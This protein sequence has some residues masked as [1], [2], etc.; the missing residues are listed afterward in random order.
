M[1][2][3]ELA[4]GLLDP[5]ALGDLSLTGLTAD[6]RQ[7]APGHLFIA[8][9]FLDKPGFKFDGHDFIAAAVQAGAV[10]VLAADQAKAEAAAAGTPVVVV[11]D[12]RRLLP[13]LA[14]RWYGEPSQDLRLVGVSGTNGK[15]TTCYLLDQIFRAVGWPTVLV[16]TVETRLAGEVRPAANTTPD[17]VTLQKLW[18]EAV[19]RGVV[20]GSMEVSSHALDQHRTDGTRYEVAI[21]TNLTQDHLDYHLDLESYFLAKRKL[22]VDAE[23]RPAS[24]INADDPY[25][26]RLL[27][28]LPDAWSF[29]L[30]EPA[31]VRAE[32]VTY[33]L[34]GSAF[35]V[36]TPSGAWSQRLPI[37]GRYN[38]AN[39]LGAIG[40]ALRLGLPAETINAALSMATGAP[41][42]LE[43]VDEGQPY[44]I[45]VDYAHTPDALD[46]A[47]RAARELT[48]GRVIT[49][50]GCGGDRDS[51]KRPQMG[52]IA[53]ELSDIAVVTS[54]NPRS[55]EPQAIVDDI[56]AGI[57]EP[58]AEVLVEVDRRAAIGVALSRA[59]AGDVVLIAGKGHEAYQLVKGETFH[60]DDRE[61]AAEWLRR[62]G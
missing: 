34:Q 61:E 39:A 41:G 62:H 52:R 50:F 36:V 28:E 22:Y 1:K 37:V 56:L 42:R 60:F 57:V 21:F 49:V 51:T 2:L 13:R 30:D 26:R 17:P 35:R 55:E 9:P 40:A 25:G 59:Q 8:L 32:D 16:G 23:P 10:A 3:R 58:K 18:R 5:G 33:D 54:D 19:N 47:V 4:A 43:R 20:G 48:A 46:N 11:D 38:I 24:V 31:D 45:L 53:A 15:T 7:V 6:S 44:A 12:P 14:A 27:A 29:G